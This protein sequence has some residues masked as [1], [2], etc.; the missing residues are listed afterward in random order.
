MTKTKILSRKN[1]GK[2]YN[3][4]KLETLGNLIFDVTFLSVR[5][6]PSVKC[7]CSFK[8]SCEDKISEIF[9]NMLLLKKGTVALNYKK[10]CFENCHK[11]RDRI[12][13]Q[14]SKLYS[15]IKFNECNYFQVILNEMG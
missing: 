13:H 8:I 15:V 11:F 5:H 9:K 7:T 12:E 10:G 14:N 2:K 4:A 6:S 3:H 1:T